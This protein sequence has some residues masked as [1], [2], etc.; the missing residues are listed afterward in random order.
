MS[1]SPKPRRPDSVFS[2]QSANISGLGLAKSIKEEE[3]PNKSHTR[4]GGE[5]RKA[6]CRSASNRPELP[7]HL[8]RASADL[9]WKTRFRIIA[10]KSSRQNRNPNVYSRSEAPIR[11]ELIRM[12]LVEGDS[13]VHEHRVFGYYG[14]R[15]QKVYFWLD[16]FL[17]SLLLDIE[18]DGEIWHH[19][20][21]MRARDRRRDSIL[22]RKYGIQ[23][24]RLK[25]Y[26][27][28]K[29]RLGRILK[30]VIEARTGAFA[31]IAEGTARDRAAG[32]SLEG[33]L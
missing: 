26:H 3:L 10:A 23:V 18:A 5:R 15:G 20:F 27:L 24:K 28:R 25:S 13:F 1:W 17:P 19:F 21:D 30:R 6:I 22:R 9:D 8:R 7:L 14:K 16:I 31:T 2:L 33:I 11:D 4:S 32:P 29:K 12:G